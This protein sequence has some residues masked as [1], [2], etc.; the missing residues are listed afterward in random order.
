MCQPWPRKLQRFGVFRS[1]LKRERV[2]LDI[3]DATGPLG[4]AI[5]DRRID[6]ETDGRRLWFVSPEDLV[7]LKAFSD[8]PRDQDDLVALIAT[9]RE[10][11]DVA[12]IER[13]V[14]LLDES[15]GGNDVSER[16]ALA[17]READRRK[18]RIT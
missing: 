1:R 7:L 2:F 8:R 11:L 10:A 18:A 15:I 5:L 4:E 12:Y 17:M 9:P 14:K 6:V 16:F 13:W 3:F